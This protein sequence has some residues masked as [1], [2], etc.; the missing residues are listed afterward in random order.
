MDEFSLHSLLPSY[1]TPLSYRSVFGAAYLTC[2][3]FLRHKVWLMSPS[4]L[5]NQNVPVYK[6]SPPVAQTYLFA[7]SPPLAAACR[8]YNQVNLFNLD[9]HL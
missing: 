5:R 1:R 2:R 3:Q 7:A 4:F 6:V 8:L 9:A